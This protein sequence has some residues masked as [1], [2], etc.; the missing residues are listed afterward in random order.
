MQLFS[1]KGI[2]TLIGGIDWLNNTVKPYARES[3][4]CH[5]LMNIWSEYNMEQKVFETNWI[6]PR[7]NILDLNLTLHPNSVKDY[8]VVDDCV[9][10]DIDLQPAVNKKQPRRIFIYSRCDTEG[11]KLYFETFHDGFFCGVCE[12]STEEN[13]LLFKNFIL[14]TMEKNILSKISRSR[15]SQPWITPPLKCIIR[16]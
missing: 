6:V 1:S 9:L 2:S 11:M 13:W 15:A 3:S 14:Q 5:Y 12:R 7:K 4:K 10:G 16:K 8:Q